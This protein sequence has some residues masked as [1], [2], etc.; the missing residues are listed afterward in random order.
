[1]RQCVSDSNPY[2]DQPDWVEIAEEFINRH[3]LIHNVPSTGLLEL[4]RKAVYNAQGKPAYEP[5]PTTLD[6]ALDIIQGLL[7]HIEEDAPVRTRR[8]V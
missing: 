8:R 4:L 1:M 2:D 3:T 7:E 5:R 6:A